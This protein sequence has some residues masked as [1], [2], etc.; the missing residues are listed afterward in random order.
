MNLRFAACLALLCGCCS[1]P[2]APEAKTPLP[3]SVTLRANSKPASPHKVR[4]DRP[5]SPRGR[6]KGSKSKRKSTSGS[7]SSHDRGPTLVE[8]GKEKIRAAD[9]ADLFLI[10]YANEFEEIAR[11]LILRR[12]IRQEKTRLAITISEKQLADAVEKDVEFKIE[13]A[14]KKIRKSLDLDLEAFLKQR[15]SNLES[16][17]KQFAQESEQILVDKLPLERLVRFYALTTERF[18]LR[19]I[20]LADAKKSQTILSKLRRG[21]DFAR[22]AQKESS[23]PMSSSGGRLP[24]LTANRLPE[25]VRSVI[26]KM[27]PGQ[28]SDAIE[29]P[30]GFCIYKLLKYHEPQAK[31]YAELSA[32]IE[33]SLVQNPVLADE[34]QEWASFQADRIG[35]K[36]FYEIQRY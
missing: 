13:D 27:R 5:P 34:I 6:T 21:A 16:L 2:P 7:H 30:E 17:R 36:R 33:R 1:A 20:V 15:Q 9:F 4:S 31:T 11:E 23:G 32:E 25:G 29:L 10:R 28:I 24:T 35:I 19:R 3:E 14:R 12:M 22:L 18:E 8:V 26:S